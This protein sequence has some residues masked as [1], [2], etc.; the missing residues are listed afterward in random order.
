MRKKIP[1]RRRRPDK[2]VKPIKQKKY[3]EDKIRE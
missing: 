1:R 2:N 3:G